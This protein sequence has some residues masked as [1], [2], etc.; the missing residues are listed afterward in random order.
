[1]VVGE[2]GGVTHLT[3]GPPQKRRLASN[4]MKEIYIVVE[5]KRLLP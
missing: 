4:R 2:G 3:Y 1:M 5:W